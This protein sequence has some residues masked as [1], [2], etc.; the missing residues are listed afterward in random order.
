MIHLYE[1]GVC[2]EYFLNK[3]TAISIPYHANI[4]KLKCSISIIFL[5]IVFHVLKM[6]FQKFWSTVQ[7]MFLSIKMCTTECRQLSIINMQLFFIAKE[8]Y[9]ELMVQYILFGLTHQ[10]PLIQ[11]A[12]M[13]IFILRKENIHHFLNICVCKY[14]VTLKSRHLRKVHF[15]NK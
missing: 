14:H 4:I 6:S 7:K 5:Y 11:C 8:K 12:S 9:V 3:E 2:S 1:N 15:L 10:W 13:K